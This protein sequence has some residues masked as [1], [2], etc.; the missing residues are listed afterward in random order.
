MSDLV[1]NF[2]TRKRK[3]NASFKWVVDAIPEVAGGEGS[4]V[5]AIV[6]SGLPEIGLNDQPT[7][8]NT[9][10]VESGEAFPT[11]LMIQVIHPLE[12]AS[13]RPERPRYTRAERSK[14]L[15]LDRLLLNSYLRPQAR[16]HLWRRF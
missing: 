13:G 7:L 15:L 14:P 5:Q 4:D 16:L 12:Q 11:L 1:H 9:S 6:I 8:E 3:R 10:L 2:A